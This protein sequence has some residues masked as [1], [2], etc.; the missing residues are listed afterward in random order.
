MLKIWYILDDKMYSKWHD[1]YTYELNRHNSEIAKL[2]QN[3]KHLIK[4]YDENIDYL[5][6]LNYL[7]NKAPIEDKYGFLRSIFPGCLT[8]LN[9]GYRIP[10]INKLVS[11]NSPSLGALLQVENKRGLHFSEKSPVGVEDRVRT[12]DPRYH[13]PML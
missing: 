2:S 8:A 9:E 7:Y 6:D 5:T 4:L 3:N 11:S 1:S 12:G 10:S 13:K